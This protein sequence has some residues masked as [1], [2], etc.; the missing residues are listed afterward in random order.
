MV[1]LSFVVSQKIFSASRVARGKM[2]VIDVGWDEE[3]RR[4]FFFLLD[5][6]L[7]PVHIPILYRK[8]S[9]GGLV[10]C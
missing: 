6:T 8:D 10:L 3:R 9:L 4:I 7:M 1:C 5:G 2:G